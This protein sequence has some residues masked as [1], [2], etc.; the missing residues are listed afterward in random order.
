M[1]NDDRW[2]DELLAEPRFSGLQLRQMPSQQSAWLSQHP[3]VFV[4]LINEDD[5][6]NLLHPA[7]ADLA[8]EIKRRG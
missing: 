4:P 2:K 1:H 5:L 3:K 8:K 6:V 7:N